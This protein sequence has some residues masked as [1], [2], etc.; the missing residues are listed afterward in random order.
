MIHQGRQLYASA[1]EDSANHRQHNRHWAVLRVVFLAIAIGIVLMQLQHYSPEIQSPIANDSHISATDTLTP[2][3]TK[4]TFDA[5]G[6]RLNSSNAILIAL[7]SGQTLYDKRA[8]EHVYPASLT[9]IMTAVVVLDNTT[10]L[11]EKATLGQRIFDETLTQNASVAGFLPGENVSVGDL[12][13]GLML[14]SGAECAIGLAEHIAGSESE[15]AK[16]MNKK[17]AGL[18]MNDTHFVN[19][20]GL[21]QPNQYTTVSDIAILLNYAL[22]YE[23]FSEVFTTRQYSARSTNKHPDGLTFHSTLFSKTS[24]EY[25]DFTL[26]GGK[27]G[28]T[29]EAGQCLASLAEAGGQKYILVTC[30]AHGDNHSQTLHIDDMVSVYTAMQWQRK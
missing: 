28:Y 30:G 17:A 25:S 23:T 1:R 18:G 21:H 24:G 14:P 16:L 19:S 7:N 29:S 11:S 3:P 27:T 10:D 26:L 9:K 13:Y 4:E 15:F 5:S 20:T 22:Q 8:W 6:L 12:L 2:E